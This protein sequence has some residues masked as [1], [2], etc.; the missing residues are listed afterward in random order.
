MIAVIAEKPSVGKD[1]ACVLGATNSK[2][3]SMEGNGY[4]VTWAFGHLITLAM[5]EDYRKEK[6]RRQDLPILPEPFKLIPRKVKGKYGYDTDPSAKAQLKVISDIFRQCDHIIVAT[7]AGREGELIF[8]HIYNYLKCNKPFS[9]LWISSLTDCAI[10]EGLA[11][12]KDGKEYD[13]LY[14]VAEARSKA[15]WMA[16]INTSRALSFCTGDMNNSLGRVQTPTLAMICR[17]YIEHTNFKPV[18]YRELLI[19]IAGTPSFYLRAD[20]QYFDLE[21]AENIYSLIKGQSPATVIKAIKKEV[22][23]EPPLLHD[24]ASLQKEANIR[25]GYSADKTLSA[26]Q[27]LYEQ[28]YITY[29]R[30][31]SRYI[32]DDVFSTIPSLLKDITA[33]P[34]YEKFASQLLST[35]KFNKK[36]VDASKVTDHHAILITGNIPHEAGRTEENVYR[37]VITRFFQS[38]M[39]ACKK[40]VTT[41]NADCAGILFTASG[42]VIKKPGWQMV[43]EEGEPDA[44]YNKEEDQL[45]PAINEADIL[46][47]LNHNQTGKKT[48][49][50]PLY[51]EATLLTAL[52]TAGKD[53]EDEQARKILKGIGIGTPA[54]RAAIIETLISRGYIERE[55]KN[56][57]PTS[58]GAE[59]YKAVKDMRI[60]DVDMTASWET[61][62]LQIEENPDSYETFLQSMKIHTR[63]MTDE[64]L[65]LKIET[66][67]K[68]ASP[69]LCPRCKQGRMVFLPAIIRCNDPQC[70]H[71]IYRK[72]SEVILSDKQFSYLLRTGNTGLIKGFK[73]KMGKP[74]DAA[75]VIDPDGNLKFDFSDNY[76]K[77]DVKRKKT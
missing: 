40:D 55:K 75:V 56:I 33:D 73:N 15:D 6:Y 74:F 52:E 4:M 27:K 2:K 63:Q 54:T 42:T 3:G 77:N 61:A 23:E 14:L 36:S 11:K 25:F 60:A 9:R 67:E 72:K 1:I 70:K 57:V 26:A 47:I 58:K 38:F 68:E 13:N 43:Q 21:E 51:T 18:P 66:T 7:D 19:N 28:K 32:P 16:G 37:L 24:L 35:G 8:R 44:K 34:Y 49:A 45:F 12:I 71:I 65:N 29:P 62:I 48:K 69:F 22:S 10:R 5:P 64:I 50:K 39:P 41:I 31:G 46:T 30:T 17:R 20:K 53:L 76:K 59:L